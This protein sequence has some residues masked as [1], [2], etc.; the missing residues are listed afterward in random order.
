MALLDIGATTTAPTASSSSPGKL[1]IGATT[2]PIVSRAAPITPVKQPFAASIPGIAL[3]TILGLGGGLVDAAKNIFNGTDYNSIGEALAGNNIQSQSKIDNSIGGIGA[4]TVAGLPATAVGTAKNIGQGLLQ[5]YLSLGQTLEGVTGT[6][7]TAVVPI[8]KNLQPLVGTDQI[9]DLPTQY[10]DMKTAIQNSPF[11]QKYGLAQH[12]APLALGGI[13]GQS[14]LDYAPLGGSEESAV[15]ALSKETDPAVI[16]TMLRKIGAPADVADKFAPAFAETKDPTEIKTM[17]QTM[18]GLQTVQHIA[19]AAGVGAE[20]KAVEAAPAET[21][22]TFSATP[23]DSYVPPTE[24]TP[25]QTQ[26][27]L[28]LLNTP[29]V[30]AAR[31]VTNS[32]D[33]TLNVDDEAR[34]DLR[35]QIVHDTYGEGAAKQDKRLD[36][37]IG[38]PGSGKSTLVEDLAEEH[39]SLVPD[40]DA[41]KKQLP[42]YGP[43][44]EGSQ[45]VHGEST[46]IAAEVRRIGRERGDN[47][48]LQMVGNDP[49]QIRKNIQI[50]KNAG[51]DIHLH[52]VELPAEKAAAR[53]V[54]R[55]QEG[56]HFVDPEYILNKVGLKP[57]QSY[58]IVKHDE[59]IKTF[60]KLSNDVGRGE[61]PTLIERG[62]NGSKEGSARPGLNASRSGSGAVEQAGTKVPE[63][64]NSAEVD[65]ARARSLDNLDAQER[66]Q[67]LDPTGQRTAPEPVPTKKGFFSMFQKTPATTVQKAIRG[68][69][70]G[71]WESIIKGFSRNLPGAARSHVLDYFGTPEFVL[72]KLGLQK[73]AEALQDAKDIYRTKLKTE[74]NVIKDWQKEVKGIPDASR[75]I[76]KYLDGQAKETKGEMTP[77][78]Y[79]VA[80][81][82]KA[83]LSEWADRLKLPA[84][85]RI[86]NYITHIFDLSTDAPP[87]SV[88]DDPDMR[89]LLQGGVAKSV[90]DP[91]LQKRVNKPNYKQDVFAALDAY[92]KR[93]TRKEAMDPALELVEKMAHKLDGDSYDYVKNYIDRV[94]MRPMWIDRQVDNLLKQTPGIGGRFSDRPTAFLTNKVRSIFY[95]GALG[96]NPASA[97]RNLSQGANTYAKLGE[98]YTTIGY[99]KL[100]ARLL[101][102]N[103]KDLVDNG[104]LQEAFVQDKKTGVYKTLLQKLDPVLFGMFETAEKINRGAAFYGAQSRGL[105]K[106]L[107]PEE[108]I[109]YAKRIVRETQFSFGQ[110]D[111]PVALSGDVMK[112]IFQFQNY[113]AKQTEFLTRMVKN[114]EFG[115]LLRWTAASLGFVYTIG[116]AFGMTPDQLLPGVSVGGS[117]VFTAAANLG[118]VA[119]PQA[120]AQQKA[121][122]KSALETSAAELFPAGGQIK[123]TIQGIQAYD[124]GRDKTATGKTRFKIQKNTSNAI[125]AALF[126]KSSLPAA[127]KYYAQ[128][129]ARSAPKKKVKLSI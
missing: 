79:K 65:A 21:G 104:I 27:H 16:G 35:Q 62:T 41:I 56:G 51:Y 89:D 84:D 61:E 28:N 11:A 121:T 15:Q 119:N 30:Q 59:G 19:T 92:V 94:N 48:I 12:A 125:Q 7:N 13:I 98:V 8:P 46:Q 74:I 1:D 106:G 101:T 37:V 54:S 122:A 99:T 60:E 31:D 14:I 2:T 50:Y 102:N 117:P 91:F 55:F 3:N 32:G 47:T 68:V 76:F 127:Q 71:S 111:T 114:K 67:Q 113:N 36:L 34:Y 38:G 45:Q 83:Y 100:F 86:S 22:A 126:G 43:H 29:E 33:S 81:E 49:E 40:A 52:L 105:A 69:D 24:L 77:V 10:Q 23:P 80:Q 72:E 78:E 9:K 66:R 124:A 123:K 42:E 97:L 112:T 95:R 4:N 58:D 64:D 88:F 57:S 118:T 87:D 110:V 75:R 20:D 25:E 53:A 26:A 115:G 107:N 116:R 70:K 93:G 120:T 82:M 96:L 103:T 6:K 73:G 129:N 108:A 39:G 128:L 109:K 17:L 5:S 90:Y 85:N 18:K 44:G 63:E